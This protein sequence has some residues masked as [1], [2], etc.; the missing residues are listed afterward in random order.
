MLYTPGT[1]HGTHHF[2][3]TIFKAPQFSGTSAIYGILMCSFPCHGYVV[4][5]VLSDRERVSRFL[6][7]A[8]LLGP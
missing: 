4:H 7:L 6:I 2:N 5:F 3:K 8:E 1:Q